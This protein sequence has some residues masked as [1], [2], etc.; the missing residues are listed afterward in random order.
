[1]CGIPI[2]IFETITYRLVIDVDSEYLINWDKSKNPYK[3]QENDNVSTNHAL[4]WNSVL[5]VFNT[6]AAHTLPTNSS[7]LQRMEALSR[8]CTCLWRDTYTS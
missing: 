5:M 8:L 2:K 6:L 7:C 1:M 3:F 4:L